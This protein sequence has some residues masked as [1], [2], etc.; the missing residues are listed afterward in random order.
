ML[1]DFPRGSPSALRL[2]HRCPPPVCRPG[3]RAV[4]PLITP[5]FAT[6]HRGATEINPPNDPPILFGPWHFLCLYPEAEPDFL[7]CCVRAQRSLG[8]VRHASCTH[9]HHRLRVYCQSWLTTSQS[10]EG[11]DAALVLSNRLALPTSETALLEPELLWVD[12]RYSVEGQPC[13]AEISAPG[14]AWRT[15]RTSVSLRL[16]VTPNPRDHCAPLT[17]S[18][19]PRGRLL[20][21]RVIS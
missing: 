21:Q 19:L 6:R 8:Y 1:G 11:Q 2:R 7:S 5:T 10:A 13:S 3:G 9:G 17:G 4:G 12:S 15:S 16:N 20:F 18:R 14:R